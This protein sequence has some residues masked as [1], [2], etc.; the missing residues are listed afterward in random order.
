MDTDNVVKIEQQK[1]KRKSYYVSKKFNKFFF[2]QLLNSFKV[3]FSLRT[4]SSEFQSLT[5]LK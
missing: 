3:S 5:V 2:K 1:K 4:G